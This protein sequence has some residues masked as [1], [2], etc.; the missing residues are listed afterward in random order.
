MPNPPLTLWLLNR[1]VDWN[2]E[3]LVRA[4]GPRAVLGR[5][6]RATSSRTGARPADVFVNVDEDSYPGELMHE[7]HLDRPREGHLLHDEYFV[8]IP[9]K[10]V[11]DPRGSFW[12]E[13]VTTPASQVRLEAIEDALRA[14]FPHAWARE[15][16]PQG[17]TLA[18]S[19][20]D[21]CRAKDQVGGHFGDVTMN[22]ADRRVGYYEILRQATLQ[23]GAKN[24]LVGYSQGGTVAR[25][26]VFLDEQLAR[27]G[28]GCIHGVVTVHAPNCGSPLASSVKDADVSTAALAIVLALLKW[29]PDGAVPG[30]GTRSDD[31]VWKFLFEAGATA[32]VV[33]FM[34]A[35]LDAEIA[36]ASDGDE[37][38]LLVWRAARKWLSGLSGLPD[39]AF[40]DLDPQRL[41]EPGS[42]LHSIVTCPIE[43]AFR[44]AVIG[45]SN[46]LTNLIELLLSSQGFTEKMLGVL[47]RKKIDALTE[48]PSR[49]YGELGLTYAPPPDGASDAGAYE[50][51]RQSYASGLDG[52]ASGLDRPLAPF[53]H[54]FA[55]PSVSQL[56]LEP[57][58]GPRHLGNYVNPSASHLSGADG[59]GRVDGR[60]DEDLVVAMLRRM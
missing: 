58:P 15:T 14:R 29:L 11:G 30:D 38:K 46:Q 60:S 17:F 59:T 31:T 21:P 23:T 53:A 40:W 20:H 7:S 39:L 36:R 12:Q 9:V 28:S 25:Y 44:G 32:K 16:G 33:P 52:G 19:V 10:C 5:R 49:L 27:R 18:C 4:L 43:A 54:D 50:N 51:L 22:L 47:F 42:V 3:R 45:T 6:L 37:K 55:V 1:S 13:I 57:T 56:V 8:P 35:L 48:R 24:V 2:R 34:N 26:L 41:V